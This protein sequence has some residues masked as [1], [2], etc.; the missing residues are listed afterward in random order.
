VI[1][2]DLAQLNLQPGYR[3]LDVGS[4]TGRHIGA[5]ARYKNVTVMGAD[6]SFSDTKEARERLNFLEACNECHGI[7]GLL[8]SSISQLPFSDKSFD[9]VLCTEVL[10]HLV[11]DCD[12]VAELVRV[13]KPNGNIVISVPRYWPERVCWFLSKEYHNMAH[14]HLRIYKRLQ[15]IALLER[16]NLRL[17]REHYAHSLHT[18]YWWLKCLAGI[19]NETFPLVVLYHRFLVWDMMKQPKITRFLDKLLNS[20]LG[21]SVVLYFKK[22]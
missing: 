14:G 17:W 7:W 4:G 15:L 16:H 22:V 3:I 12:A 1:S 11:N 10:E 8:L 5:I 19:K 18:P 6:I 21:K 2:V 20:V 13:L 9:V